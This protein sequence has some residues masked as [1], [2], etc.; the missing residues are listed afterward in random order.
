MTTTIYLD[1]GWSI[2]EYDNVQ[3]GDEGY[4]LRHTHVSGIT[5]MGANDPPV[6][7]YCGQ[8]I[9]DHVIGFYNLCRW[10]VS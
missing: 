5:Y 9:P 10:K 1:D 7:I 6:C 3:K 2:T 8:S 4:S